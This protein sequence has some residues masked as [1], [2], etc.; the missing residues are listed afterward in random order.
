MKAK[1]NI[2]VAT[3]GARRCEKE[4]PSEPARTP[5]ATRIFPFAFLERY[6][7]RFF[8]LLQ[9]TSG[10]PIARIPEHP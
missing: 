6:F 2:R 7:R 8:Y 9:S 10:I 4:A 5:F 1:G 3:F